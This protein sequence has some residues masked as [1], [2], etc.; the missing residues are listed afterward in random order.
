M[1]SFIDVSSDTFLYSCHYRDNLMWILFIKTH[2]DCI[3]RVMII[4]TRQ[5]LPKKDGMWP[6]TDYILYITLDFNQFSSEKL[7]KVL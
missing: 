7:K 5:E 1:L 2:N 6:L 3:N 4:S